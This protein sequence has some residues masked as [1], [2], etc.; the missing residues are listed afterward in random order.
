MPNSG[1][2]KTIDRVRG[3]LGLTNVL[4]AFNISVKSRLDNGAL[5]DLHQVVFHS[6]VNKCNRILSN[7]IVK[8]GNRNVKRRNS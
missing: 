5:G 2:L 7:T 4:K 3:S 8:S 1:G 6:M